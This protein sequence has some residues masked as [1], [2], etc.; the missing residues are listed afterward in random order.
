MSIVIEKDKFGGEYHIVQLEEAKPRVELLGEELNDVV[1]FVSSYRDEPFFLSAAVGTKVDDIFKETQWLGIKHM[2]GTYSVYFS[3][4]F[5]QYR[6]SFYGKE[7]A[8]WIVAV[9]GDDAVSSESFCA[10]YKISGSNFYA[11]VEAAA[12]SLRDRYETVRLR[13]EKSA[14]DFMD[15]FGWCTWDSF[16]DLVKGEDIPVGLESF[17]EGGFVPKLVILDDGWQTTVDKELS[18]GQWELSDFIANEKFGYGLKDT[19]SIAKETYGVEKFF[20][21]HAVLGYW[22]GVA[23]NVEKMKK[24]EPVLNEAVHT[25]ELRET[26]PKRWESEKF[27]FGMIAPE[28]FAEFYDDYHSYLEG[29]GIDGVKIDVQS[30]LEGHAQGRGG[31]IRVNRMMREGLE[32]SVNKHFDGNVI[33]CMSCSND[34]IYHVKDSNMMRSSGDFVPNEPESHSAHVFANAIHSIWMSPFTICDWDMFQTTHEYGPFHAAARAISG[35]PVYVSDRVNEHDFELIRA[36]TD[37]EGKIL[38]PQQIALPT[39]DCLFRN[40]KEDK[41]L[42]KIFNYNKYNSVVGV[43]AFDEKVRSTEVSAKDILGTKDE[44]RDCMRKKYAVY[45]YKTQQTYVLDEDETITVELGKAEADILTFAEVKDGFAVIGLT[46]KLNSGGAVKNIEMTTSTIEL[47]VADKGTLLLYCEDR[48][49]NVPI[50]ETGKVT[51]SI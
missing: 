46:E 14:P 27:P 20:V 4:A 12:R 7:S 40:P 13:T 32:Q 39:E 37:A 42:Y 49:V 10:Y 31:R 50:K 36:L 34:I 35:G 33:N 2:D 25:D 19:V 48:F 17:K 26:G 24:Y 29:E 51:I 22:G 11:L 15:Y 1:G 38:R 16:Y 43:F 23:A 6:T 21:W 47:I 44:A 28:H 45:S 18:R 30:S 8:L 5:E 41:G 3:M 9:T